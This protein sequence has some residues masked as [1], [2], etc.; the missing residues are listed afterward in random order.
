[1]P[2]PVLLRVQGGLGNQLFE[3]AAALQLA[4][5][6]QCEV[7]VYGN[8]APIEMLER[9]IDHELPRVGRRFD[10]RVPAL[11]RPEAT[12]SA[13]RLSVRL[14]A[15]AVR[16][17][18]NLLRQPP[19][20][21][22]GEPPPAYERLVTSRRPVALD[23]YFQH[24]RYAADTTQE[25]ATVLAGRVVGERRRPGTIGVHLR[26]GDYVTLGHQLSLGFYEAAA[27][28]IDPQR[29]HDILIASDDRL[30]AAHLRDVMRTLGWQADLA[31]G[32]QAPHEDMLTLAGCQHYVMSN[33]TY[34]WWAASTGD[35]VWSADDRVV[36][37]PD[38]WAPG[39]ARPSP[40]ARWR[41]LVA[42]LERDRARI[43]AV[44]EPR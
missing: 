9:A 10:L 7:Q 41:S 8:P 13:A 17:R 25:L 30:A 12:P 33:S 16:S 1:M 28:L 5:R 34:S 4:H 42:T 35:I 15:H 27:E 3:Y 31:A 39:P 14:V 37:S 29:R 18:G 2:E 38:P 36:V 43:D 26:R 6:R 11:Y 32:A 22:Y 23:G 40:P 21:S 24:P 20:D 44:D 19:D